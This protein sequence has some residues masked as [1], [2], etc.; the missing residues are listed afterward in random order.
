MITTL[1]FAFP[2]TLLTVILFF[3]SCSFLQRKISYL[4]LSGALHKNSK[5]LNNLY[6]IGFYIFILS[7]LLP[8]LFFIKFF[9]IEID[10]MVLG[11]FLILIPILKKINE[12]GSLLFSLLVHVM[13]S[14]TIV[15]LLK[16]ETETIVDF[17]TIGFI[18]VLML[19]LNYLLTKIYI[20]EF[21]LLFLNAIFTFLVCTLAI[22]IRD[23]TLFFINLTVFTAS[24]C[25]L[26]H[27]KLNK[28]HKILIT[29]SGQVVIGFFFI[30]SL[31][32]MLKS[33]LYI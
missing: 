33:F 2:A 17:S 18:L 12:N 6:G 27:N 21:K 16:F 13:L 19:L 20:S 31:I 15:R 1:L 11:A 8:S 24:S 3:I 25:F 5:R 14:Y 22:V 4:L 29:Q 30:S 10:M 9:N 23:E 26:L 32:Y 28:K 7:S